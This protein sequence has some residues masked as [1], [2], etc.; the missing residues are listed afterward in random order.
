M[1]AQVPHDQPSPV[2]TTT[3][4]TTSIAPE[5]ER[6]ERDSPISFI[7]AESADDTLAESTISGKSSK[8]KGTVNSASNS[9]QKP[10]ALKSNTDNLTGKLNNLVTTDLTNI[11]EGRDFP[12]LGESQ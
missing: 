5:D 3:P 12:L 2:S 6:T 10:E 9:T 4:D 11:V 1:K 7:T 8:G